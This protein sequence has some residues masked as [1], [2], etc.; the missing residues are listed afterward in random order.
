MKLDLL[1]ELTEDNPDVQQVELQVFVDNLLVYRE[2][3]ANVKKNGSIVLH[4]RT[5]QPIENPF[6]K[7][8]A[9]TGQIVSK[10][11]MIESDRVIKLLE[12]EEAAEAAAALLLPGA[13]AA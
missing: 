9:Q 7:V 13:A 6:L 8:Q 3:R 12:E 4:P 1:K 2:A 10:M 11:R 5:S